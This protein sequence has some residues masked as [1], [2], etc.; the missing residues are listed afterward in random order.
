MNIVI[1]IIIGLVAGLGVGIALA[2]TKLRDTLEKKSV[3]VLKDAE[4]KGEI[5]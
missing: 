4:E 2:A 1:G 5:L 3:Q